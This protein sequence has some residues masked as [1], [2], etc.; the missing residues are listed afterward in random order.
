MANLEDLAAQ[1]F[2]GATQQLIAAENPYYTG[3]D[4][5]DQ[6][7]SLALQTAARNPNA[8][9]GETAL[10]AGLSGLASGLFG[11]AGDNYQ[12]TLTDRYNQYVLGGSDGSDLSRGLFGSADRQKKLFQA[13]QQIEQRDFTR[14]ILGKRLG[15]QATELGK[16]D[17]Y[18]AEGGASSF[19]NPATQKQFDMEI[20]LSTDFEK[21]AKDY[22]Y[23][24]QGFR[25]MVEAFKDKA[26]TS[27]FEL[28]RRGSQAVEP[29]L[30]VR[31]DDEESLRGAASLFGLT[32]AKMKS[33][34]N[35]E[36]QLDDNVRQGIMRIAARSLNSAG[37]EY[38]IA[39]KAA[40]DRAKAYNLNPER[41]VVYP[42]ARKA[43]EL[44]EG[45]DPSIFNPVTG[46]V[47]ETATGNQG[48]QVTPDIKAA[49]AALLQQRLNQGQ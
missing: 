47:T 29:G 27:D 5:A 42:E 3:R 16:L 20:K 48:L 24:E 7:A 30:A 32:L 28:I 26:G 43:L 34:A 4:T 23:Q 13:A 22:R 44:A 1:L 39:R 36:T 21:I 10:W 49:A 45:L 41:V 12:N 37:E 9:V 40:V 25:S 17:A 14:D 8:K 31:R 46:E 38:T 11:G 35:G 2:G 6:I 18:G 19:M 33:I 15:A